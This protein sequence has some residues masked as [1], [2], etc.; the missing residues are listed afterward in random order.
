[1]KLFKTLAATAAFITCCIGNPL[2]SEA[3]PINPI[4]S[5]YMDCY[6][7]L[8]NGALVDQSTGRQIM[9]VPAAKTIQMVSTGQLVNIF[10]LSEYLSGS[11][12]PATMMG[13]SFAG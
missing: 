4:N 8:R 6:T 11:P 7:S 13:K 3:N 12:K 10:V 1:M 9:S 2:P 5:E